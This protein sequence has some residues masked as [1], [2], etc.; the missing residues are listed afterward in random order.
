MAQ[1]VLA[2]LTVEQLGF[3]PVALGTKYAI[4]KQKRMRDDC[5]EWYRQT[6]R[7][8]GRESLHNESCSAG[9]RGTACHASLYLVFHMSARLNRNS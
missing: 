3:D 5:R 6:A 2:G 1:P 7:R 8:A 4:E 9:R